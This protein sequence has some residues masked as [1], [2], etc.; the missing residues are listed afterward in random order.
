[1]LGRIALAAATFILAGNATAAEIAISC[2]ALGQEL[3]LCK[4]GADAWAKKTGN[5]VKVVSTPN[6]TNER[7]ALYQQTAVQG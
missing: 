5:T 6:D 7:L 1:M 4:S 2:G 3:A